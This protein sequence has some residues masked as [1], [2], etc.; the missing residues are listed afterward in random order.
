[1]LSVVVYVVGAGGGGG[2]LFVCFLVV[3]FACIKCPVA[4]CNLLR[5]YVG[6]YT[7]LKETEQTICSRNRL[8]N[9]GHVASF[10]G[11]GRVRLYLS[12]QRFRYELT[13]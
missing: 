9:I 11:A 10:S 12:I 3:V 4:S 13:T 1:M 8:A 7:L 6:Q 2:F 5:F